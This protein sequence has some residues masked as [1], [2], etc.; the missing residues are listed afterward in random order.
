MT[1]PDTELLDAIRR[2]H[3]A[4]PWPIESLA[5]RHG[6]NRRTVMEALTTVPPLGPGLPVD[7]EQLAEVR[8]CLSMLLDED[9]AEAPGQRREVFELYQQLTVRTLRCPV[10]YRWVWQYITE[11]RARQTGAGAA[12]PAS[13]EHAWAGAA[14]VDKADF[15]TGLI[16]DAVRHLAELAIEGAMPAAH[17]AE[18][19]LVSLAAARDRIDQ[20]LHEL[21]LTGLISGLTP[22]RMS[23]FTH[24]PE[25]DLVQRIEDYHRLMTT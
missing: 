16:T 17:G 14:G 2:D 6:V 20:A 9:Q 21:A 4:G 5:E 8:Q 13:Y 12:E 1:E 7:E 23:A 3:R 25:D 22:A 18:L 24:I 10:S 11:H 19:G 15:V